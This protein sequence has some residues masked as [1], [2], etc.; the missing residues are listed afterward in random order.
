MAK[1]LTN[2]NALEDIKVAFNYKG[3]GL[4]LSAMV[5]ALDIHE[6]MNSDLYG[7]LELD[8]D[9]AIIDNII[10]TGDEVINITFTYFEM[11]VD[12]SFFFN[13]I[14]NINLGE[15]DSKKSYQISLRSI[16]DYISASHLVSKSYEGSTVDVI[17]KIYGE[18]FVFT[19]LVINC[20]SPNTGRYIAPNIPPKAAINSIL[21][22]TTDSNKSDIFMSQ[23]LFLNGATVMDSL[24]NIVEAEPVYKISPKTTTAKDA[25]KGPISQAIGT[26][27]NVVVNDNSDIISATKTGVKGL[28][29]N[30]VALNTSSFATETFRGTSK[31]AI[32][33]LRTTRSNM[34]D[35]KFSPLLDTDNVDLSASAFKSSIAFSIS[36]IA[37]NTPAIPGLRCGD[38]VQM[39]VQDYSKTR[40]NSKAKYSKKYSNHYIVTGIDHHFSEGT[41]FQNIK[42]STGIA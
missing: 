19:P 7:S 34:Y 24:S 36:A 26:P 16:N 4:D 10:L 27:S 17:R 33:L 18:Y 14:K 31:P 15:T 11:K 32:T 8:D 37:Y 35:D 41:Y 1:S 20:S 30:N 13:G 2:A 12:L 9:S 5:T 29:L 42:L 6:N 22:R 38:L 39:A 21:K 40:T 28:K 25:N 3:Q 23:A